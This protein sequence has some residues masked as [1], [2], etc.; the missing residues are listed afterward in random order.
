MRLMIILCAMLCALLCGCS[1]IMRPPPAA[2][3]MD[4]YGQ[5]EALNAASISVYAGNLDNGRRD[6]LSSEE[7]L[8]YQ[9][10]VS[11]IHVARYISGGYFTFG[12]GFQSMTGFFLSGFVSPYFGLNFWSNVNAAFLPFYGEG[13]DFWGHYS[14]GAMAIE[15]IPL[16]EK[17]KLGVTQHVSKN[18][19]EVYYRDELDFFDSPRPVFYREVGAGVYASYKYGTSKFAFEFRYGRDIDENRN[20]FALTVDVW[21][22]E[23]PLGT[24]GNDQMKWEAKRLAEKRKIVNLVEPVAGAPDSSKYGLHKIDAQWF[25]VLDTTK[26]LSILYTPAVDVKVIKADE[27]CYDESQKSVRLK[28]DLGSDVVAVPLDVLDYCRKVDMRV[29]TSASILMGALFIPIGGVIGGSW[30]AGLLL[31]G[32]TTAATWGL[33]KAFGIPQPRVYSQ[34]CSEQHSAEEIEKWLKQYPCDAE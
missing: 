33:L 16:N 8:K 26:V 34:L 4:S 14:G 19:R 3:F 27:I 9:E 6:H 29:P 24:G 17:W 1:A 11:D 18:G 25:R 5:D 12:G 32:G 2:A 31:G 20:R 10:W 23:K 28:D 15:Q 13:G 7:N 22:F 30:T 21:G